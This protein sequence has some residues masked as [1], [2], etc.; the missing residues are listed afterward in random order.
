MYRI[1]VL[2][3]WGTLGGAL[4]AEEPP[5]AGRD[6]A[7]LVAELDSERQRVRDAAEE[8]LSKS[9]LEAVEPLGKAA[10]GRSTELRFR[11]CRALARL[12]RSEDEATVAAAEKA[13]RAVVASGER[14][15]ADQSR[16]ALEYI[17]RLALMQKLAEAFALFEVGKDGELSP[18]PPRRRPLL[19]FAD[20][21]RENMDGTVWAYGERGRPRA[22]L[23][24]YP[25][26]ADDG[27]SLLW[28]SDV[29]T[30]S[31]RP[32]KV[33]RVDGREGRNWAPEQAVEP[34][35]PFPGAPD[36]AADDA[37]RLEQM[38]VL[39]QRLEGRQNSIRGERPYDLERWP[40][41]LLRYADEEAGIVD[42]ALFAFVHDSN[43]EILVLLEAQ[44]KP[45]AAKWNYSLAR[46][47]AA[48][49]H[50]D[51]DGKEIWAGP[52]PPDFLS[53]GKLP[54][55]VLQRFPASDD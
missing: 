21:E 30:L 1:L 23:S 17:D 41:P 44:G 38:G 31:E 14:P 32:L 13:L 28:W 4:M 42:G 27:K 43:P 54:Y 55:W 46:Q 19:R 3:A 25:S 20:R 9:G 12:L 5:L 11:A 18:V 53:G 40:R 6:I 15:F 51:L 2:M 7:R 34:F 26:F 48:P 16:E 33:A 49:L 29:V 45:D 36:P 52:P 8:T 39:M 47:A 50:V 22:V 35:E 10:L 24:V 37:G